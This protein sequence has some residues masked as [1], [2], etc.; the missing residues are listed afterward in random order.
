MLKRDKKLIFTIAGIFCFLSF[1]FFVSPSSAA[2]STLRGR[3]YL[4]DHGYISFNCLDDITGNFLNQSGNLAGAGIFINPWWQEEEFH[5]TYD[6]CLENGH[7]VQLADNGALFG[8][9]WSP[10]IGFVDFSYD[11]TAT[12]RPPDNFAF[13]ANC[14]GVCGPSGNCLACYSYDTQEIYGWALIKHSRLDGLADRWIKLDDYSPQKL[15]SIYTNDDYLNNFYPGANINLGDFAG[16]AKSTIDGSDYE[17]SFNC[18]TEN[19]P[20]PGTCLSRDNYKVYIKDLNLGRLSAPNWNYSNACGSEARRA[21]L[22][23][24]KLSGTQTAYEVVVSTNNVLSTSTGQYA[25]WSGKVSSGAQQVIISSAFLNYNT[26]YYW[27]LRGFDDDDEPT[28][29]IQ[30][31]TNNAQKDSDQNRDGNPLTFQTFMHEMPSPFFYWEPPGTQALTSTSTTFTSTSLAFES[32]SPAVPKLCSNFPGLCNFQWTTN[33]DG[34]S[35]E[36]ATSS[37]A[38]I[39]FHNPAN[40]KI[41]LQV[42]DWEGYTCSTSTTLRINYDL[43]LWREV[44]VEDY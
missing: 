1:L 27:W 19:Y 16:S 14:P 30:Y 7:K 17:L 26:A 10:M 33:D 28:E 35:I 2:T 42:T 39:N 13:S 40:T 4:E 22:K 6:S 11:G 5:F 12:N 41:S 34:A 25:Y 29:W 32:S 43:P 24:D 15:A 37:V 20:A 36:G 23:W 9:A 44:K 38:I 8:S 3:A 18:G 21:V 31:N